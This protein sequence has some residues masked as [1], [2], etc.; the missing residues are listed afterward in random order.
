MGGVE[1]RRVR[2]GVNGFACCYEVTNLVLRI[3]LIYF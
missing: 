3:M 2:E 1:V